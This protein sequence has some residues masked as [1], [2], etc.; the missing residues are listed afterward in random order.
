MPID[1][2]GI[3]W[4][5]GASPKGI[6]WDDAPVV[7][8][9]PMSR[10]DKLIRGLIDPLDAGAQALTKVLSPSVVDAGNVLNNWLADKTGLVAKLPTGGVDQSV[11][12]KEKAYQAQRT[13]AGE[14]GFDGYRALGN[15]A[16]PATIAAG[17]AASALPAVGLLA[18]IGTGAGTG[19]ATSAAFTPVTSGDD[20]GQEKL[21]QA[22]TGAAFGGAFP[23]IAAGLG[24]VI[25][26]NASTNKDLALMLENGVKPTVGQT[27]G[28][29]WNRAEEKLQTV[30]PIVGDM[31]GSARGN[32]RDQFNIAA[33][34][35]VLEPLGAQRVSASGTAAVKEAGDIA[36]AAIEK[37]KQQ[38]GHFAIDRQGMS[39]LTTLQSMASNLPPKEAAAF[40]R[41]WGYVGNEITPN[42]SITGESFKM[43]QNKL[44]LESARFSGVSDAYQRQVGDAIKELERVIT[45]NAKRANPKAAALIDAGNAAWANLVRIEGAS[46]LAKGTD[47]VFTP[48]Q[49]LTAVKGADRSVRDRATARG[50]ALMQDIAMAGQNVLGNKVPDSGTA[51]RIALGAGAAGGAALLS[52][53]L[54]AG[55]AGGAATYTQPMQTIL[56]G[57]LS[58]RPDASP[59]VRGLLNQYSPMI[60]PSFGLLGA[61]SGM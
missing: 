46:N 33:I 4:D 1:P 37:G 39:E 17:Y 44:G 34:N 56:R 47:G 53:A 36:S 48:G 27:L 58:S 43:L 15:I 26:P 12:D 8:G 61:E 32:A 54:L 2:N 11:R 16:S 60:A 59:T 45:D 42:G 6:V 5:D 18:R 30:L 51:G 23:A 19:A 20:F 9:P 24:R 25:S 50:D 40:Q 21:K 29:A 38:L 28:G 3:T 31:I 52:P 22:A 55:M 7:R 49:L 57:L 13:A 41:A 14:T 35:R 10:M